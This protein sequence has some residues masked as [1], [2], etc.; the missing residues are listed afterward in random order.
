MPLSLTVQ[1]HS[2]IRSE[3]SYFLSDLG[4]IVAEIL[5]IDCDCM[6]KADSKVRGGRKRIG[7]W[8]GAWKNQWLMT[9]W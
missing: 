9:K 4:V 5:Q 2:E 3:L 1:S 6:S 7:D 8:T